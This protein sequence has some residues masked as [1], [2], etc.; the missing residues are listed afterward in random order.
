MVFSWRWLTC[1]KVVFYWRWLTCLTMLERYSA[2]KFRWSLL[3][4]DLCSEVVYTEVKTNQKYPTYYQSIPPFHLLIPMNPDAQDWIAWFHCTQNI[5][6]LHKHRTAPLITFVQIGQSSH[7]SMDTALTAI[8]LVKENGV[9]VFTFI[10]HTTHEMQPLDTA[11]YGL[12][13]THWQD[14]WYEYLKEE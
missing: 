13:Q 10:P 11:V 8:N 5:S 2:I 6:W 9:I 12:L 1:L 4:S 7:F 3:T 14:A